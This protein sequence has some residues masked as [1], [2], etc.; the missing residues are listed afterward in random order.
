M[1][2]LIRIA[3]GFTAMLVMLCADAQTSTKKSTSSKP[4]SKSTSAP[5][6]HTAPVYGKEVQFTLKNLAEGTVPIF[7]GPKEDMKD[8]LKRKTVGGLST[9]KMFLRVNEVVCI[10]KGEKTVACGV[11][12]SNTTQMEINSS[13]TAIEV[14]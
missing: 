13:A 8:I 4:K 6:K 1:K 3:L 2:Y 14:K 7:A 11:V 5:A 12:K 9:N 10:L